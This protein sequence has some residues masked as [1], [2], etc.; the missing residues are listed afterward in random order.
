MALQIEISLKIVLKDLDKCL[1]N[2]SEYLLHF[3]CTALHAEIIGEYSFDNRYFFNSGLQGQEKNHSSFT[4]SPEIF[5][6][7]EDSISTLNQKLRK[8]V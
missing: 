5:Q 7:N 3:I 2:F 1:I 8:T 6:E 4:L